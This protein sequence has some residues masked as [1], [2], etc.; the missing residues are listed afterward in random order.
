MLAAIHSAQMGIR[1][2]HGGPFG[3]CIVRKGRIIVASHNT[4]VKSC[5]ATCHAEINAIRAASKK[6]KTPFLEDTVIYSTTEPCPMCFAAIHWARI[7]KVVFGTSIA[8]VKRRG[9]NELSIANSRLKKLGGSSVK[10][11][12]GF[13][14][15]KCLLMLQEWDSQDNKRVY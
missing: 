15:S 3:A 7:P 9:F 6:L 8:D 13:L 5:D 2:G 12:K 11:R 4:V 10:I 1:L 14:R